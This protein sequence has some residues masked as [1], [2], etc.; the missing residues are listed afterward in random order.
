MELR[1]LRYFISVYNELSFSKAAQKCFVSQPSISTATM[2]L[3]EELGKQ[4]F[5]R[6]TKGVSPTPA[7]KE[8]YPVALKVLDEIRDMKSMFNAS[9]GQ[10]E[11][12][13]AFMPYLSGKWVGMIIEELITSIADLNLI[14]VGWDEDADARIISESMV[15]QNEVFHKLWTDEYIL[16]MPKNHDLGSL[17]EI[18]LKD[19]NGVSF[20]S[21][22]FCDARDTWNYMLRKEGVNLVSKAT[23]STE[24]YALDLVAAGLG[25]SIVPNASAGERDDIL[26]RTIT[27]LKLERVVGVAYQK[28]R[29]I[30]E[31]L[32][33]AIKTTQKR[34][35]L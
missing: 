31:Q 5:V 32:L 8:F 30:S 29:P 33:A 4:L 15:L 1:N 27:D 2:Q 3:E 16:V 6:H 9:I 12:R 7:G 28:D 22:K 21:R 24:E 18:T 10:V 13:I 11:L 20:V 34:I 23:I 35:R 14:V 25:V 26:K 17:R 19:L